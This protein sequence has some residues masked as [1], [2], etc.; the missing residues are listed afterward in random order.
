MDRATQTN[1][2]S[3]ISLI[4]GILSIALPIIG[5]VLGIIGIFL[6]R[7]AS[8]EIKQTNEQGK[9]IATAGFVCSV[10]GVIIQFCGM[11]F[12]FAISFFAVSGFHA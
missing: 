2:K 12:I 3:I 6:S 7:K 4:L 10:V 8:K 9:G 11:L 5:F 1:N